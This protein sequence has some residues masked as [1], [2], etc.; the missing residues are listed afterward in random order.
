M[1]NTVTVLMDTSH[2]HNSQ[3]LAP[4][5]PK[6]QLWGWSDMLELPRASNTLNLHPSM[7]AA[8][9][10]LTRLDRF[11]MQRLSILVLSCHHIYIICMAIWTEENSLCLHRNATSSETT[12]SF[13][14]IC[15]WFLD[16]LFITCQQTQSNHVFAVCVWGGVCTFSKIPHESHTRFELKQ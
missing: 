7:L 5:L 15:S 16:L 3:I 4:Y 9:T 1:T 12:P 13:I 10:D 6:Q 11:R 2:Q 8:N 14:S